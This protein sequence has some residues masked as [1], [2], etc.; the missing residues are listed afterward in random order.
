LVKKYCIAMTLSKKFKF[1]RSF[2]NLFSS[3][4]LSHSNINK[5]RKDQNNSEEREVIIYD[6]F[7]SFSLSAPLS[8]PFVQCY[9]SS[10]Q[11]LLFEM[12]V[13]HFCICFFYSSFDIFAINLSRGRIV[14]RKMSC[15]KK[16][17]EQ[18]YADAKSAIRMRK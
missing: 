4:F 1:S 11:H 13:A 8:F 14:S 12:H 17:K 15:E 16:R 9:Y 3:L 18:K 2:F 6:F 5:E 10:F 7:H